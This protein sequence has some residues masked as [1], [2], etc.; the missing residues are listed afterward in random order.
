ME[1]LTLSDPIGIETIT[2]FVLVLYLC[3]RLALVWVAGVVALLRGKGVCGEWPLSA[4]R[5]NS[6]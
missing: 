1:M 5:D 4:E 3:S 2:I 6:G